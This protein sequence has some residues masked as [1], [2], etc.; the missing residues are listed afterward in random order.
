MEQQDE[1]IAAAVD[2]EQS[3]LRSFIRRRVPDPGD[4]EEILQDVFYELVAEGPSRPFRQK[5]ERSGGRQP[6]GRLA[7]RPRFTGSGGGRLA[8]SSAGSSRVCST[9]CRVAKVR[10]RAAVTQS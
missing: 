7:R 5:P 4:V 9:H 8:I 3:R 6:G 2:Q 10:P 1:R